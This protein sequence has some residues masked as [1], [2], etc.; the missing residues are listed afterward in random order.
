MDLSHEDALRLNVLLANKPL[1]IR[2]D[3]SSMTLYGLSDKGEARISLNPNCRD[4]LYLRKG[5]QSAG[6]VSVT[7]VP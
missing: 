2:I 1:A 5:S 6:E 4:D 7:E 3:E